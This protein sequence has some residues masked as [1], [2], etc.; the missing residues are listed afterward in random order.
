MIK[1]FKDKI[2]SAYEIIHAWF[3]DLTMLE[4]FAVFLLMFSIGSVVY[5]FAQNLEYKNAKIVLGIK[6]NTSVIFPKN[7]SV[8]R[9]NSDALMSDMSQKKVFVVVMPPGEVDVFA[10]VSESNKQ[11]L[12][13]SISSLARK[14]LVERFKNVR[15]ISKDDLSA[16][17]R[18]TVA[19]I[20]KALTDV[21]ELISAASLA[22]LSNIAMFIIV[23]VILARHQKDMFA[24]GGLKF[25]KP[26]KISGDIKDL[27]G[28]ED[29]KAD[30]LRLKEFLGKRKEFSKYGITKPQNILF[31]GPPGTGKTKLA[32]YLAKEVGLPILFQSAAN[33]ETGFVNG[34]ASTLESILKKSKRY[35]SCI[36][37]LDEAQ[38][39]FMKRGGSKRK[40]DDDTQN[41][42][43]SILDG[44]RKNSDNEVIWIVASNFNQTNMEMDEAML[45]RFQLKVDFRLPNEEERIAIFRHYL[46]M[47]SVENMEDE[48][49]LGISYLAEITARRS[50]ADIE[51]IVQEASLMAVKE[52][53]PLSRNDLL[54]A[55]ERIIM[56][57]NDIETTKGME[58]ERLQIAIHEVGHFLAEF[59]SCGGD[60]ANPMLVKEKMGVLKISLKSNS[61]SGALGFV[62]KRPKVGFLRTQDGIKKDIKTLYGGTINEEI[63]YGK[64]G[65][66][67]GA[68]NDIQ[69]ATKMLYHAVVEARFFDDVKINISVISGDGREKLNNVDKEKMEEVS[70]TYYKETMNDLL[71][72]KDLSKYLAC[73]LVEN[74]EMSDEEMLLEI[75]VFCESKKK[76]DADV[77]S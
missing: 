77:S 53:R 39:L 8:I 19:E 1:K 13:S 50:P 35:K 21:K 26:N 67:N 12:V 58:E 75:K 66:S 64:N 45:R 28:M 33:M 20:T 3:S 68:V 70:E 72:L 38:D 62:F 46:S 56:G 48:E 9:A 52:S 47:L 44:V 54:S 34:G 51:T 60:T 71:A 15:T 18:A 65:R 4:F 57:N 25:I 63:F 31:S 11:I 37:F 74:V 32:G 17:D 41:T 10:E 2:E 7:Y 36:V 24:K 55:S 76:L 6:E 16:T 40:F 59:K 73:K 42:L 27:I 5:Q 14:D 23:M 43:L 49:A 22:P 30:V 61:R 69:E 29:I